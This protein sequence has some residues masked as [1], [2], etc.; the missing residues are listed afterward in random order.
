[1]IR[2]DFNP[3]SAAPIEKG[4][5]RWP[6]PGWIALPISWRRRAATKARLDRLDDR[7][8]RDVGL[9]RDQF[10]SNVERLPQTLHGQRF[11]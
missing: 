7:M 9:Y 6:I 1:M 8:L 11:L 3:E 10:S 2:T 4:F 5:F